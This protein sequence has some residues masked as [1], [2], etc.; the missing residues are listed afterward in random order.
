MAQTLDTRLFDR[1]L[2][3]AAA[4]LFPL[5]VLV[6]F[7]RTY[8]VRGLFDVPPLPS[9]VVHAHGVLMTAWV[10]LFT[11]Q[12]WLISSRRIRVHQRL[13]YAGIG[14]GALIVLVGSVTAVRAARYGSASTPP[15]ISPLA[16]LIV[17][18][19]DLLMFVLLFGGAIYYRR[20]PAAHKR[21]MLLTAINFLPP[22]I[23][24]IPVASLQALG[25]LWIFGL[26]TAFMIVS[27]GL[28]SRRH[29]HM[30]RVFL[31]G[32]L[33]LIGSYVVRLALMN[34]GLWMRVAGWLT[35]FA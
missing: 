18:M 25:P 4:I 22:A 33:A 9:V 29:H 8:C 1:R 19:F 11:T 23:G 2:Y 28:D 20:Q 34:T 30:N 27:L 10:A 21:L 14:L 5:I 31:V 24:R 17:P 32:T 7:G 13:G 15:D 26:P 3:R 12:I 16:F 35:A 6:G